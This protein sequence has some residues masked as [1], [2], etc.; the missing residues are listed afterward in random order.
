MWPETRPVDRD[1]V[2]DSVRD[3][4]EVIRGTKEMMQPCLIH[5]HAISLDAE[6]NV[7]DSVRD[8]CEKRPVE[9]TLWR[10]PRKVEGVSPQHGKGDRELQ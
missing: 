6:Y 2:L 7:L 10:G 3:P 4:C 9:R 8:P 5:V 1:N